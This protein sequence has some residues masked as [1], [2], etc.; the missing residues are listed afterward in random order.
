M[1]C[2]DGEL[3]RAGTGFSL[4][5]VLIAVA[6]FSIGMAGLAAML[7]DAVHGTA[8][9]RNRSTAAIH[10]SSL[11]ELILLNPAATGHYMDPAPP[12]SD[13]ISDL[14]C[15]DAEWAAGNLARWQQE[16]EQSL[17]H[18][19]TVVCRDASPEDGAPGE[20][21]CDGAENT[22]VKVLWH[23]AGASASA[24]PELQRVAARIFE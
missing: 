3:E 15:S 10:A 20:F 13:C 21:T 1:G 17:A 24:I 2:R 12:T 14:A 9:A 23:E 4:I 8:E 7:M 11:A 18:A 5:E 22:V 19:E 16:L 6:V